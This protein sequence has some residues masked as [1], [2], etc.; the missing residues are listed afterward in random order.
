MTKFKPGQS[1]NPRGRPRGK[2]NSNVEMRD[3]IAQR[4]P[5]V[6]SRVVIAALSGD[7]T[8]AKLLLDR[9]LPPLRPRDE[10]VPLP[11][12]LSANLSGRGE[13]V[14]QALMAGR[15]SATDASAIL[16]ALAHQARLLE[17][18]ELDRRVSELE[19]AYAHSSP[20]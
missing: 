13:V 1:G 12:P 7:M 15:L 14:V 2:R 17:S 4:I 10:P 18:T 11:V 8:A 5:D 6:V 3:A 9:V 19:K 16:G 20:D